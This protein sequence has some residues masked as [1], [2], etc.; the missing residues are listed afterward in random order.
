MI[1][2]LA[3]GEM[4]TIILPVQ[5]VVLSCALL[6]ALGAGSLMGAAWTMR[7]SRDWMTRDRANLTFGLGLAMAVIPL[8]MVIAC[9]FI[10]RSQGGFQ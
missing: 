5:A 10:Y 1:G 7:D 6:A 4:T 3:R 8:V 2:P 9:M